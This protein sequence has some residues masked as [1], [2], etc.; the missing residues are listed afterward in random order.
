MRTMKTQELQEWRELE[1]K[2]QNDSEQIEQ[3]RHKLQQ[4]NQVKRILINL[5]FRDRNQIMLATD[6]NITVLD[7]MRRQR[8]IK[9]VLTNRN[10]DQYINMDITEIDIN[11]KKQWE[12]LEP[13]VQAAI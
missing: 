8:K 5:A 9:M 3:A 1:L 7:E 6:L 13:K 12:N 11:D 2:G 10:I 4:F